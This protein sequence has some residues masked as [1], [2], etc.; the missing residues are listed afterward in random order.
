M[1]GMSYKKNANWLCENV[2]EMWGSPIGLAMMLVDST[3]L[4][5]SAC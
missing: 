2:F 1:T 4:S 3:G 5:S